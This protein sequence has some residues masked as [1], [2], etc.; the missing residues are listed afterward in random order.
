M[1]KTLEDRI[2]GPAEQAME[3]VRMASRQVVK[4][5]EAQTTL[6]VALTVVSVVALIVATIAIGSNRD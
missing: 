5:S 4:A 3:D 2:F 1:R 6:L